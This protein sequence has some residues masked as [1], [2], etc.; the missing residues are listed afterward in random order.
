[1]CVPEDGMVGDL[2]SVAAHQQL[3]STGWRRV[4]RVA[5]CGVAKFRQSGQKW[6]GG[7]R[8]GPRRQCEREGLGLGRTRC[9]ARKTARAT[10]DE[11]VVC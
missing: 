8:T 5:G 6:V 3:A 1:L 10:L 7:R 2:S 4:Q 11:V 9:A